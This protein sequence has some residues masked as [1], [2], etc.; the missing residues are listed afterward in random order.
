MRKFFKWLGIIIGSVILIFAAVILFLYISTNN[1]IEEK[2]TINI[3]KLNIPEDSVSIEQGRHRAL[4]CQGCHGDDLAGK[5][6]FSSP[7]ICEIIAPNLTPGN[8]GVGKKYTN[9]DWVR[10]I[11]HGVKKNGNAVLIMPSEDF[12]NFSKEDLFTVVSFLKTLPPVDNETKPC[13]LTFFAKV[14][15]SL[16]AFGNV[17]NAETIEHTN[18]F[19]ESVHIDSNTKFG[20]YIVNISG[21]RHCHGKQLNGGKVP[22]PDSPPGANITPGGNLEKWS[23]SDFITTIR[24]GKTPEGKLLNPVFMPWRDFSKMSDTEISAIYKYLKYLPKL[25]KFDA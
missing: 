7:A 18:N 4:L 15:V 19:S 14:L 2:Y 9:E 23:E 16:G 17:L 21:C 1:R 25:K 24:T 5:V 12:H 8:G 22:N 20:K 3:N 10:A 11:Y 13:R 6:V